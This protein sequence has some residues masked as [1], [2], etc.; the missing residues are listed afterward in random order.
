MISRIGT[1]SR[2]NC[3]ASCASGT[4][5]AG[6]APGRRIPVEEIVFQS[7]DPVVQRLQHLEIA[8]HHV[9]EQAVQQVRHSVLGHLGVG[10]SQR[11]ITSSMSKSGL[12]FTVTRAFLVT[13][14]DI[15][16]SSSSASVGSAVWTPSDLGLRQLRAVDAEVNR[17]FSSLSSLGRWWL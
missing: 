1:A 13:K 15:S 16:M 6:C 5:A 9:V 3:T 10:R 17:W 11:L 12:S 2:R 4:S 14:I 7:L 8:V